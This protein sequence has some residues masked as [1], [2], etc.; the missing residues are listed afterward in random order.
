MQNS[1]GRVEYYAFLVMAIL[2]NCIFHLNALVRSYWLEGTVFGEIFNS[3]LW[4]SC[5]R[6]KCVKLLDNAHL[7]QVTNHLSY[8]YCNVT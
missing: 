7:N 6:F 3:G 5:V 4:E 1:F 8:C 2:A